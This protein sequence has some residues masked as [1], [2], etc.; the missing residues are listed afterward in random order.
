M[1]LKKVHFDIPPNIDVDFWVDYTQPLRPHACWYFEL[2]S[3]F[4]MMV[5][6][7]HPLPRP[8][9][10]DFGDELHFRQRQGLIK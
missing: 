9:R 3:V 2:L 7:T 4:K 1:N 5:E 8:R 10:P 6:W